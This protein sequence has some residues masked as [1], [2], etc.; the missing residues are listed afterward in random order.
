MIRLPR[1][2]LRPVQVAVG[3]EGG[4]LLVF[5]DDWMVAVLVRLAGAHGPL[6]GHWF[7][8][9]GY[10]RFGQGPAPT[11]SDEETAVDWF[12]SSAADYRS[13]VLW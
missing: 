10:G 13:D 1:I 3:E 6:E 4:G 9:T 11:F 8:E 12:R 5:I 7:L 2:D